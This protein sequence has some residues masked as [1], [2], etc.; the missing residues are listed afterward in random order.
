MQ[1]WLKKPKKDQILPNST[2]YSDSRNLPKLARL[3]YLQNK[4]NQLM[5]NNL[6]DQ[7]ILY[8]TYSFKV[9]FF[10]N[11]SIVKELFKIFELIA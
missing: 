5:Q 6:A 1:A 9:L 7:K 2:V 4:Y 8:S 3:F 10:Q 11:S